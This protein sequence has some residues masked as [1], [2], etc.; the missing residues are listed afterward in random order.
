ME[1][2]TETRHPRRD[3]L[4]EAEILADLGAASYTLNRSP[5]VRRHSSPDLQHLSEIVP[6]HNV[7]TEQKDNLGKYLAYCQAI[8]SF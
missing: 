2:R 1:N 3:S 4:A 7:K 8:K 5:G 6:L